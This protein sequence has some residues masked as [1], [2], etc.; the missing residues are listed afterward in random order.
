MKNIT[1]EIVHCK[2]FDKIVGTNYAQC[3]SIALFFYLN[4]NKN[5]ILK[6]IN[7]PE[8]TST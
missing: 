7:L 1:C 3:D 5:K 6:A 4:N 8:L 2:N